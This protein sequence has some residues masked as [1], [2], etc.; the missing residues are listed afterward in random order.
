MEI[1]KGIPVSPGVAICPAVVVDVEDYSIPRRTVV[2]KDLP[3]QHARLDEAVG[4]AI[5]E[6]ATLQNQVEADHGPELAAIFGFHMGMLRDQALIDRIHELVDRER[7]TAEYALVTVMRR[8]AQTFLAQANE[9]FRER[10]ADIYDVEKR[11]LHQLVEDVQA[12]LAALDREAVIVAHDLTP[13]QTASLDRKN[14]KGLAT[15]AGGRTSHTAIVARALGIPAVVG[16]EDITSVV[17][18]TDTIIIDGNRGLVI[19]NPDAEQ[20][21]EY[22]EYLER[23]RVHTVELSDLRHLPAQTTDGVHISLQANIEFSE[24]IPNALEK[25]AEGVGLYR[26]EYLYL[27]TETEPDEQT[28]YDAFVRAIKHIKGKSLTIRT[29]DL[30]ADKYTQRQ[31]RTPESNP[32]LGCRSIRFC[33]QNLTMFKTHLNA[34]MRASAHGKIRVMFPLI[35]NM[36]E[37]RQARM[38][39]H[40]VMEDLEERNIPF[41]RDVSVG[42]M[43]EVPS[44][45]LMAKT[46]AGEVDFF[47]IGT[48]DLVQYT[49]A[50][51]RGNEHV[52]NLYSPAHP[53]VLGLIKDVIRA[54]KRGSIDVSCCGEM[55]GEVE[56][57]MLLVGMGLR[58]LSMT[59]A[60]IPEIK[61]ILRAVSVK[62]CERVARRVASYD[63]E[64]QVLNYLREE[65]R[66]VVPAIFDGR[67]IV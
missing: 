34:I 33:L 2:H 8:F 11:V 49:L 7:V 36:L 62:D 40:D 35:S 25:G 30:G 1:K 17:T 28:Q 16:L 53:A 29:L 45:A 9:V 51:D 38:I 56:Y 26:T 12:D 5:Q 64:R 18:N 10:V 22:T 67:A 66:K 63:S 60:A 59:P 48:N 42:M 6:L 54:A 55:A 21:A 15:D 52:A 39:L 43:V 27:S 58:T 13:S 32:F 31:A 4:R 3:R 47:S 20:T 37:L 19:I 24:E 23:I 41:D 65:T 14:I 57:A 61:Q 46:F 50:V 44:A